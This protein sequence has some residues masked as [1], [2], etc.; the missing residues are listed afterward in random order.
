MNN[1]YATTGLTYL[2]KADLAVV[3]LVHLLDHGLEGQVSLRRPQLLHHQLQLMEINELVFAY[4]KPE[5]KQALI[6]SR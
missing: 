5:T 6:T 2:P 3:I 1:N 4:I